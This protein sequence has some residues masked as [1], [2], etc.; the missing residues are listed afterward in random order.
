MVFI[1]VDLYQINRSVFW[2][3]EAKNT[4]FI[5][6]QVVFLAVKII[7]HF[8]QKCELLNDSLH[9][10]HISAATRKF[11]EEIE[12]NGDVFMFVQQEKGLV[13]DLIAWLACILYISSIMRK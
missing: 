13:G 3:T 6:L 5:Y 11:R 4:V 2:M 1:I 9:Q 7:S 8:D 12:K 10:K